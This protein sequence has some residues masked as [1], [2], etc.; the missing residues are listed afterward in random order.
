MKLLGRE[1][2]NCLH[3][4]VA[5]LIKEGEQY[6]LIERATFPYAWGC[7]AGHIDST[8]ATPEDALRRELREEVGLEAQTLRLLWRKIVDNECKDG[9]ALHDYSIYEVIARGSVNPSPREV[10]RYGWFTS[11]QLQDISLTPFWT[12]YFQD[13]RNDR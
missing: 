6:F 7:V 1:R 12:V 13:C 4:V 2:G 9:T 5:A 3:Y 8:D 10:K 11:D